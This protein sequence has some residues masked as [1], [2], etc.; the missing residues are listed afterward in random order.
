M[1]FLVTRS[2]TTRTVVKYWLNL[3]ITLILFIS[4]NVFAMAE[5]HKKQN[6][7]VANMVASPTSCEL[8][9]LEE[10][11]EMTFYVLWETP[12]SSR[13][14]LYTDDNSPAIRCWNNSKRGSI[15]L[16]FSG[17]ILDESKSYSLIDRADGKII[18]TVSVPISGTLKQRQRAQRR[19][20]GFWRM[21]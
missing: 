7:T 1:V 14:C 13:F 5:S 20:R 8:S 2:L 16:K 21:F 3:S 11:C 18:A 15:E 4:S 12:V 10:F 17:H 19:R 9:P 6:I